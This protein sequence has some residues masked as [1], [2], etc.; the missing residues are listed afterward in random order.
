RAQAAPDDVLEE[1]QLLGRIN[2]LQADPP[3]YTLLLPG[4][5]SFRVPFD[6]EVAE[7]YRPLWG[8]WVIANTIC[9]VIRHSDEDDVIVEVRDV[10]E[11]TP[12][13]ESPLELAAIP[14]AAGA[15]ALP[16]PLSVPATFSDNLLSFEYEPLGIVAYGQTR[17]EAEA[18]FREELVWLWEEYA[19]APEEDLA[20]DARRLKQQLHELV[21]GGHA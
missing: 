1:R 7:E 14:L 8:E 20:D 2:I 17:D 11:V 19:D 16:S 6:P 15:L 4:G 18:A 9:R 10:V 13:D 21:E 5:G 3:L 12:V